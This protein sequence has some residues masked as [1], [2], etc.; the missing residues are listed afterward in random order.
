MTGIII[1]LLVLIFW[2]LLLEDLKMIKRAMLFGVSSL[3]L[4]SGMG[5]SASSFFSNYSTAVG[6]FVDTASFINIIAGF[7]GLAPIIPNA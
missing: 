1:F 7:F 5:C 6:V 2:G 4:M 3:V